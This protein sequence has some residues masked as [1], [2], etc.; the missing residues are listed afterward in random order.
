MV[1][2]MISMV[3]VSALTYTACRYL[4]SFVGFDLSAMAHDVYEDA[5][6][7]VVGANTVASQPIVLKVWNC[8]FVSALFSPF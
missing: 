3:C 7:D 5:I 4:I 6:V 8:P 1:F 2:G